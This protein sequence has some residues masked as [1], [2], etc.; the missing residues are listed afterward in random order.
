M[1]EDIEHLI[2]R[3]REIDRQLELVKQSE[4]YLNW[5]KTPI[6]TGANS[7]TKTF[8]LILWPG[9]VKEEKFDQDISKV[10]AFRKPMPYKLR[11]FLGKKNN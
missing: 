4:E 7:E 8:K 2:E 6:K 11:K 10:I 9:T 3:F 1:L 5:N